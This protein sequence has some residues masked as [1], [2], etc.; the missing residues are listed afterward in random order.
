MGA[1]DRPPVSAASVGALVA[2]AR[3]WL[4]RAPLPRATLVAVVL[5]ASL[6]AVRLRGAPGG[7]AD[8]SGA[9]PQARRVLKHIVFVLLENRTFDNVFGRFP[10]ADGATT[11]SVPGLGTLALRHAPPFGWHDIDHEYLSALTAV[12]RGKMDG[13]ARIPGGDLNGDLMAYQQFDEADIPNLW[14]YAQRFTLG[15][16][17]FS[18]VVGPSFPNHLYSVAAQSGGVVTNVQ[19]NLASGWGCDSSPGAFTQRLDSTGRLVR[20]G[21]CF[22]FPSMADVLERLKVP[23]AYYAAAQPDLGYLFSPLDAFR[24]IRD[25]SLWTTRVKDQQSFERDARAGRLPAFS[26]VTP[27]FVQSGHPPFAIC[28]AENWFVSKMNALMAGPD[29][30]STAVFLVWDDFGGFYDHVPPPSVD[31]F[32]LGPRV[33]LLVISPYAKR[34]YVSHTTYSFESVLK[35]AEEIYNLP[36]LSAR[37]RQAHDLLD[38]FN[39]TQ[40]PASPLPLRPRSCASSFSKADYARYLPAVLGQTL[41]STLRLSLADIERLH[42]T[43]TLAQI[44]ARQGVARA[45][46]SDAVIFAYTSLTNTAQILGYSAPNSAAANAANYLAAFNAL[47]DVPPG[48]PL[49]G[50]LGG[51]PRTAS[52]PAGTPFPR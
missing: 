18:S 44:A 37:D 8:A 29:W 6:A 22:T 26:W 33:P 36:P 3:E 34:G 39:F 20:A 31:R 32:G 1:R 16:H 43:R 15:D 24:S 38:A 51:A 46:L 41:S 49:S 17:M 19:D 12:D 11:A 14:R 45:A 48:A 2:P 10:G 23:W 27:T 50:M 4:R 13:F 25:T 28:T 21:T 40:R 42:A 7:P 35:T 47:L 52:L 5:L 9:I 30:A